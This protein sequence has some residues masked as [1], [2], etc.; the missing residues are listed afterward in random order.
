MRLT[1]AFV[2]SISTLAIGAVFAKPLLW[3]PGT[4]F[5]AA[6]IDSFT[7]Q[8]V[9]SSALG[10]AQTASVILKFVFALIGF[11]AMLGQIACIAVLIFWFVVQPS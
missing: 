6:L 4:V 5:V 2:V 3:I 1:S 7:R 9:A 11:Y 8:W 10:A